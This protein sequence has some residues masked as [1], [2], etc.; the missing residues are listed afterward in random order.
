ML[1]FFFYLI[2]GTITTTKCCIMTTISWTS[3]NYV[4]WSYLLHTQLLADL[5]LHEALRPLKEGFGSYITT[6]PDGGL[7]LGLQ[8]ISTKPGNQSSWLTL[9]PCLLQELLRL[10]IFYCANISKAFCG[11]YCI[12]FSWLLYKGI[13]WLF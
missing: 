10:N 11:Q 12:K 4:F 8:S 2:Y 5:L 6:V 7:T 1:K 13:P 9:A 3:F